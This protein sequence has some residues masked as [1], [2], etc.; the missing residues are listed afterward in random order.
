MVLVKIETKNEIRVTPLDSITLDFERGYG[1]P[2]LK[3]NNYDTIE[4]D[5][6][7]LA[8]AKLAE[9]LNKIEHQENCIIDINKMR[10]M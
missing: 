7:D 5:T 2:T 10:K 1:T 9:I 4:F 8:K 6:E 3:I